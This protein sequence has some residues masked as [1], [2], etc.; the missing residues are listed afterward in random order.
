VNDRNWTFPFE[1]SLHEVFPQLHDSQSAWLAQIDS[2]KAPDRKTHELIRMAVT[3]GLRNPAGVQRHARLAREV[4][5]TWEE[6]LG[7]IML[8]TPG[9]GMLPAVEA[10][11]YA[12]RGFEAATDAE[13][14]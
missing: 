4:G 2:L 6:I 12:R 14:E 10:I 5:A 13:E 11:P 3:V 1:E 8:T 9:H 7:S